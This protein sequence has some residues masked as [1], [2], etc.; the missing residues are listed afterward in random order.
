VGAIRLEVIKASK[1]RCIWIALPH[2]AHAGKGLK[3]LILINYLKL[4]DFVLQSIKSDKW[5]IG[6]SIFV[7]LL[8]LF[9]AAAMAFPGAFRYSNRPSNSN[10]GNT[11]PAIIAQQLQYNVVL[12]NLSYESYFFKDGKL[13]QN[14]PIETVDNITITPSA[15]TVK[16]GNTLNLSLVYTGVFNFDI[17]YTQ[18]FIENTVDIQ[19]FGYYANGTTG[20]LVY[21]NKP[22]ATKYFVENATPKAFSPAGMAANS[23]TGML[24]SIKPTAA[25]AGK[26][27]VFC[28]G[29]FEAFSNNTKWVSVFNNVT[30]TKTNVSNS[31]VINRISRTCAY[32][33]VYA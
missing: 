7:V 8:A 33:K 4:G 13:Y 6:T 10:A 30:Y 17:Y 9:L 24:V 20:M 25:A 18:P 19:Y 26:T 29:F 12:K 31:T 15:N 16:V 21:Y 32:V 27:W 28:G 22:N 1:R 23:A 3:M 5:F 2:D 14:V 11:T